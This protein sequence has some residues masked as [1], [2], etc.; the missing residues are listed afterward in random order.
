MK[1]A[2]DGSMPAT[3]SCTSVCLSIVDPAFGRLAKDQQA[4]FTKQLAGLLDQEQVAHDIDGYRD[5]PPGLRIWT[6]ATVEADDIRRLLPWLDWAYGEL[7][8]QARPE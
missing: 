5:A 6:G 2:P 7:S 1:R 4:A 8:E 3:R